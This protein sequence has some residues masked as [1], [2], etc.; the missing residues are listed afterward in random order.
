MIIGGGLG[1]C[2]AA[3]A[4]LRAGR[5]VDPDRADRLDR[6]PAHLA[7]RPARRASLDRAV[8]RQ[9]LL[10]GAA[11]GHPRLLPPP[12]PADRRRA[13]RPR[14]STPATA[15]SR[16]SAT[17]HGSAL[18]VLTAM[19]APYASSG[20]LLVLLEHEPVRAD[21]A[22]RPRSRRH[23]PRP[24]D[25]ARADRSS[26]PTSSTRPSWATCCR[27]RA[28]SSSPA[29]RRRP[30]PASRTPPRRTQPDNQQA[31]TVLLRGRLPRGRGPHD[32]PAGR[33]RVLARLR[34]DVQARLAGPAARPD[35]RRPASRSSRPAAG[36]TRAAPGSGCGSTG[37]SST[38]G[39]SSPAPI[40]A[41]RGRRWSTGRRTTTGSARSSAPASPP[42][43]AER[44]VARAKQL[45]LSLLYWLQTEC[46]RPDGKTG[47]KGLRLRPDLVGTDDGLAKAPYIRE[48][49]RIEAEFTVLEQHVGTEARRS[50]SRQAP[51]RS[52]PSRSPTASAS[53]ATGSTCTRAP[54]ATT[55]STSAR[56]RSRSRS[57]RLIPRRVE[58]LLPACKNLGHDPH[59]Q[60]L[61][62]PASRRVGHRRGRR[63]AG[64]VLRRAQRFA[65]LRAEH[66]ET[67][68][69][70][71]V[72]S[73]R[74]RGRDRLAEA[75]A[76]MTASK[77]SPHRRESEDRRTEPPP[78][79]G[80]RIPP[81]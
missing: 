59:H 2:A 67:P 61:L 27:W 65:P 81:V 32:R 4:A 76:A 15:A 63:R 64:G 1:G 25:R 19:L 28:S 42:A 8:R 30:R 79:E 52:R 57:G 36:S 54:A 10:P 9:R 77:K 17:S 21:V 51:G 58:N 39:T 6:R 53:A 44:H 18:A 46:P 31:I 56:C 43:D 7:G 66:A 35:L 16:G 20:R 11:A 80:P 75:H 55:T 33:V 34:P 78:T 60:R 69:R 38:P 62:P 13:G 68:R 41:A 37:G 70:L 49:R 14:I 24:P 5:T 29:P 74:P 73:D 47:W 45:S 72:A 50:K 22:G 3:L 48:S 71:P 40:P 12:L 23:G 26:P